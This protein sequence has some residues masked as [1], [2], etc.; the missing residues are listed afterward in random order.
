MKHEMTLA[1]FLGIPKLSCSSDTSIDTSN[2]I[3]TTPSNI[4]SGGVNPSTGLPL[5]DNSMIDVGGNV[6]G[7][8]ETA[9]D[10]FDNNFMSG[11]GEFDCHSVNDSFI[12]TTIGDDASFDSFS[13]TSFD[14]SCGI[15]W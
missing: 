8:S 4:G 5:I 12:D 15:D 1:G 3:E 9:I 10:S 14:D 6:Y 11:S 7:A 13:D 2:V